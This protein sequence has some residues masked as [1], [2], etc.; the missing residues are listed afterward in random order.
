MRELKNG[1]SR[2]RELDGESKV[3]VGLRDRIN[4]V[5]GFD[6]R[7]LITGP[8]GTGKETVAQQLHRCGRRKDGPFVPVCCSSVA[9]DLLASEFFG[10]VKGAFT[11]AVVDKKGCFEEA[12]GG[13]LF[14]DEVGL[15]TMPC[16]RAL[17]R[18]IEEQCI[19]RVGGN[20]QIPVDIRL[21]AA[22]NQDLV[23]MVRKGTFREDLFHRLNVIRLNLPALKEHREDI[24]GIAS[25]WWR[26]K[27]GKDISKETISALKEYEFPGNIRELQDILSRIYV[28]GECEA[29]NII[30][31]QKDLRL[32]AG[33]GLDDATEE[34]PDGLDD[35]IHF[36]VKR[37]LDECGG[38]KS[39]AAKR[40]KCS[41]NTV[42]KYAR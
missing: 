42:V 27:T 14:L 39:E 8:S 9:P 7:V 12:D 3:M 11:G 30:D 18:A 16:Q 32:V 6:E 37:I 29:H 41:R 34:L 28:F 5:S 15:M 22:T 13:T 33:A 1:L 26:R 40:L 24:D 21:I 23:A 4:K 31:E 25:R 17:L 10:H 2:F 19:V 20:K 36:H 38:N 35:A